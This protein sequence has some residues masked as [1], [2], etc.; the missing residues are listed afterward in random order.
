MKPETIRSPFGVLP[1]S[2]LGPDGKIRPISDEERRKRS[3]ALRKTLA[4]I[5][6][7][8]DDDPPGAFEEFMRAID[9]GRSH[10]PMFK[11]IY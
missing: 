5:A 3:E 1:Q 7:I 2:C 10:R 6:Q 9:E 11:G 8:P 4:A